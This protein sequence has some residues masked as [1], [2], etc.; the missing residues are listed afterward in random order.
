MNC[1]MAHDELGTCKAALAA[2]ECLVSVSAPLD[3]QM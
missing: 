3:F 2:L 1:M